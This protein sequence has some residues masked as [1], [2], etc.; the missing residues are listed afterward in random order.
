M[1]ERTIRAVGRK[2][3]PK[4]PC[5]VPG[6]GRLIQR[7]D[8]CLYH[9]RERALPR[10]RV[11]GCGRAAVRFGVC[12]T[13]HK[14]PGKHVRPR[15][16]RSRV[17]VPRVLAWGRLYVRPEAVPIVE[18]EARALG[19][20]HSGLLAEIVEAW[21]KAREAGARPWRLASTCRAPGCERPVYARGLCRPHSI[22]ERRGQA[23]RPVRNHVQ[24]KRIGSVR[25]P[26]QV[27]GQL[28]RA[29]EGAGLTVAGA[30]RYALDAGLRRP[31]ELAKPRVAG[32]GPAA[33]GPVMRLGSLAMPASLAKRLHRASRQFA[34]PSAEVIRRAVELWLASA[35][36]SEHRR[37]RPLS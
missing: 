25:L 13:H 35:G 5:A 17:G 22:Q 12:E 11:R 10:C 2:P 21:A 27:V 23:L 6:C 36:W 30:I 31:A 14:R 16:I 3:R 4:V 7:R 33:V 37:P 19:V 28:R 9:Y 18:R 24:E 20:S 26:A 34:I 32:R 29:A 8:L 1:R 15:P